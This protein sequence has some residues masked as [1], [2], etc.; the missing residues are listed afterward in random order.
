MHSNLQ[1]SGRGTLLTGVT[2]D[3]TCS[4]QGYHCTQFVRTEMRVTPC[5][6]QTLMPQQIC[7][8]FKRRTL[9][10]QPAGKRMPQAVPTKVLNS[11]FIHRFNIRLLKSTMSQVSPYWGCPCEPGCVTPL[12]CI[13]RNPNMALQSFTAHSPVNGEDDF[14][15]GS[16][17]TPDVLKSSETWH[18]RS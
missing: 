5:H 3:V 16:R 13:F 10:S 12:T 1:G 14:P 11:R 7:D 15:R 2:C 17:A 9:H 18:L 4:E 6:R 8:V